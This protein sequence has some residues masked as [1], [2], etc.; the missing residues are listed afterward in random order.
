MLASH[1]LKANLNDKAIYYLQLA[2]ERALSIYAN[3]EAVDFFSQVVTLGG[4]TELRI[5]PLLRAHW[6]RCLGEALYNLGKF[7]VCIHA[8]TTEYLTSLGC[9]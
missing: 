7:D 6:H 1:Y 8:E 4:R 5:E 3:T 2:G 9:H